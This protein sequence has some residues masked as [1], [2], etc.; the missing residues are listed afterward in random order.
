VN[1][2]EIE[3]DN[4]T[5]DYSALPTVVSQRVNI[6]Q[7]SLRHLEGDNYNEFKRFQGI[8]GKKGH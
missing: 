4:S 3:S 1:P 7:D 6:S 8:G 2:Q 5:I